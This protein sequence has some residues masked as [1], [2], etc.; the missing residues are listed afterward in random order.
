MNGEGALTIT[1]D[2]ASG[3]PA[4]RA[5]PAVPGEFVTIAITDTGTGIAEDQIDRIFEPVFTTKGVGQGTGLGLSQVFG[6]A[7]QSG[8]D[9]VVESTSGQGATFTLYLPRA[10]MA[11]RSEPAEELGGA[12]NIGEGA[13]ILVVEDNAEVGTF[14]TQALSELGYHTVLAIDGPSALVELGNDGE[15]FDAVFSDVVMP[16]MSG[17]GLGQEIR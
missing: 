17:I 1:V 14:A 6:F 5:H 12:Q 3:M 4:V 8:G 9:I 13:C 16:G 11:D 2:H 7:K 15:R 10:V